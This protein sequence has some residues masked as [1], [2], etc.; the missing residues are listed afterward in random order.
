M[1]L[2]AGI[3]TM[4]IF[5]FMITLHE[6]G[7][8][9]VSKLVGVK[10]LEFAVGMGPAL[11]KKQ[12]GETLYSLRAFPVGGYCRLDGE[13]EANDDPRAFSNQKL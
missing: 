13:D 10:V 7:H 1:I 3:L 5:L 11:W 12:K 4:I 8:F 2:I 6:F 9:I